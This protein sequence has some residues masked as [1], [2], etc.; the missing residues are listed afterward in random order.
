LQVIKHIGRMTDKFKHHV[1]ILAGTFTDRANHLPMEGGALNAGYTPVDALCHISNILGYHGL[2][3][4][5]DWWWESF[6]RARLAGLG[7]LDDHNVNLRFK[8]KESI[9]FLKLHEMFKNLKEIE[10]DHF[11]C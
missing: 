10:N 7:T 2:V 3:Y 4:N 8:N 1:T 5:E 6:G 9:A 11:R